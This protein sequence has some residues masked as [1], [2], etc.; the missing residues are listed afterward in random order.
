MRLNEKTGNF[1][2]SQVKI[3][4]GLREKKKYKKNE[5]CL[6]PK[7]EFFRK[8]SCLNLRFQEC[9]NSSL[10]LFL[11]EEVSNPYLTALRSKRGASKL[12]KPPDLWTIF[13][14]KIE[15]RRKRRGGGGRVTP[16]RK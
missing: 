15:T 6:S 13:P 1:E 11:K 16:P 10:S 3:E 14:L 5:S 8:T 4:I 2:S 7:T 9:S 12:K